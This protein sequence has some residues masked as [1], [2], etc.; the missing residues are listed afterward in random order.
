MPEGALLRAQGVSALNYGRSK[1]GAAL[2]HNLNAHSITRFNNIVHSGVSTSLHRA[3]V[4][5]KTGLSG[6]RLSFS[7]MP[8]TAG[9][10][11]YL[12]VAGGGSLLKVD[13]SGNVTDWG[14]AAPTTNLSA[15]VG[16]AGS[17]TGTYQYLVTFLNN[18]TGHRSIANS[19]AASVSPTAQ[20]VNL[21]DIPISTD[22]QVD[23]REIWRTLTG[24]VIFF[25]LAVINNNTIEEYTDN[26]I[27]DSLSDIE[28]PYD[29]TVP[30]SYFDDCAGPHNASMFWI[31]R[32]EPGHRGHLYY[33]AIGRPEAMAG[34]VNVTGDDDPLQKILFGNGLLIVFSE[35]R[36]FQILGT[37]PYTAR[38]LAA[39]SGTSKP[40]TTAVTSGGAL[41]EANDGVRLLQG[42]QAPLISFDAV[43][44]LF[45][46]E[47]VGGLDSFS[48]EVAT[49][50]RGEY[51]ISDTNQTL[52]FNLLKG[53][54]RNLGVGCNALYYAAD[55]DI[56]Y[57]TLNNQV[58]DLE[59]AGTITDAGADISF[60]LEPKHVLLSVDHKATIQWVHI[61]GITQDESFSITLIIDGA[62][63]S[64]G[65]F[66][67]STIGATKYGSFK[68]GDGTKYGFKSRV[69][70]FSVNKKGYI[71]GVRISG[72][73][74]QQ[75]EIFAITI[76]AYVPGEK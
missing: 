42:L 56:I 12:F 43:G 7:S 3:L 20:R 48:G 25:R 36:C 50:A 8:P 40:H 38:E 16:T 53:T 66:V 58:V 14:I 33:S 31:T 19:V 49:Y 18:T 24:G 73:I 63:V 39:V 46:G 67:A 10:V 32:T 30:Y 69:T 37:N 11:D 59:K 35:S 54:W 44:R 26:I 68:Y 71:V 4:P 75:V 72:T 76:D 23:R 1:P 27:D 5:V 15:A 17:L 52:A 64:L 60:E 22:P 2:V 51:I 34:F 57:A 47:S 13:A 45:N 9:I 74:A 6:N 55:A 29:N 70:T 62:E 28:L 61:E 41:Y 21:T 65:P